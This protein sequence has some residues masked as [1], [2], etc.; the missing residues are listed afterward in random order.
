[1][2]SDIQIK[3]YPPSKDKSLLPRSAADLHLLKLLEEEKLNDKD[4][5]IIN[6]RFGYL[7]VHLS[8]YKP[9]ILTHFKSQEDAIRYNQ[10]LN[11]I[12]PSSC[13][14][15]PLLHQGLEKYDYV[16]LKMPKSLDLFH[17][18]LIVAHSIS[19]T[20][21]EVHC[22]FMTRH[23]S[24]KVLELASKYFSSVNQSL[25]WKKSRILRL[26][27]PKGSVSRISPIHQINFV[28]HRGIESTLQQY[29]GVFS[30]KHID[31][32]TQFLLGHLVVDSSAQK[33]LDLASG[34]GV[35]AHQIRNQ[36][37]DSEI[38]LMDDALLAVESSK[39]NLNTG[40]NIFH[41]NHHLNDFAANYFDLIVCNPPFHFEHENTIDI[42]L[43]LFQGCSRNT[44]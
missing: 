24:S 9:S 38:H 27:N 43:N 12:E 40:N 33:I 6:D 44:R 30:A 14:L 37:P 22:G 20:D 7:S 25:A 8:I 23:F 41:Y 36:Q 13:G 17:L 34:N 19:K 10:E 29:F 28:N 26:T 35:I 3:R 39:L 11:R 31:Y 2:N 21:T 18:F 4:L 1:M 42:A 15:Y 32:A 5:V 16:L